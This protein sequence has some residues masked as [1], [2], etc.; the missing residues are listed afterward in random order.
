[1]GRPG[2]PE[3]PVDHTIPELG[4]LAQFL[5]DKRGSIP[6]STL[7]KRSRRGAS[8]LKR[9]AS[10]K[11]MPTVGCVQDYLAAC[12]I[13]DGPEHA[14]AGQLFMDAYEVC[15][16][17]PSRWGAAP[18]PDLAVSEADL[19]R[20][21][22]AA[23]DAA[24]RPPLR[25]FVERVGR[26]SLPRT[27]AHRIVRGETMPVD[28]AQYLSFLVAC[29]VH[30]RSLPAWFEAWSRVRDVNPFDVLRRFSF[31]HPELLDRYYDWVVQQQVY[32]RP[33]WFTAVFKS[34]TAA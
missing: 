30:T 6:Y 14:R 7:A 26:H 8:P 12:G 18:R 15:K 32:P 4:A 1:M 11:T 3:A 17:R 19:S 34:S 23:Y 16:R 20:A 27:T 28:L 21:L 13:V 2:R 29:E 24:G 5:R 10:G 31:F 22:R 25:E 33:A 9:A